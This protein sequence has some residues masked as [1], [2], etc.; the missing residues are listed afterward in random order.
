MEAM[1]AS[2]NFLD[3]IISGTPDGQR[4]RLCLQCG[5]CSGACPFG[6]IMTYPP[7]GMIAA[8]RAGM[9]NELIGT[10]TGWMCVS[11]YACTQV[12][13]AKIPVTA[14]LTTQVKEEM[15][16]AGKIIDA[17]KA[18]RIG[19]VN[20][21][22]PPNELIPR[23]KEWAETICRAGP[24]ATRAA[25]EA[26]IRGSNMSLNDALRLE[27]ALNSYLLGTEDFSEGVKAF[28]EKRKPVYKG[29]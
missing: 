18:E 14:G 13:P 8:L 23:A 3:E 19:L 2:Q 22:V 29:K 27:N 1:T 21:V 26:M 5:A 24:L 4:L 25:K 28:A 17:H 9:L 20:E 11:C 6:F 15:L 16:L 12:C 7:H 10:D